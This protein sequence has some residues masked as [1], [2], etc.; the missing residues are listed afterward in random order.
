MKG[1]G[2]EPLRAAHRGQNVGLVYH[3]APG[4][5]LLSLVGQGSTHL[6]DKA[7]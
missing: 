1:M 7:G 3:P 4:L 6:V 2:S 5:G